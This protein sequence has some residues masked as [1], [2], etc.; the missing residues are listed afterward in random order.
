[1]SAGEEFEFKCRICGRISKFKLAST[2]Q[3]YTPVELLVHTMAALQEKGWQMVIGRYRHRINV[4][5]RCVNCSASTN[6][7]AE[8]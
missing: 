4:E 1:M 5:A 6:S 3:P 2:E 8:F 7:V